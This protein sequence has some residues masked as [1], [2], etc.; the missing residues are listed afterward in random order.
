MAVI[1]FDFDGTISDENLHR[2][3]KKLNREGNQIWVVTMRKNTEFNRNFLQPVLS[4][5][6]LTQFNV[7][8]CN[9]KPKWELLKGINADI[10]IDNISDEFETLIN[11]TNVIPFLWV[12]T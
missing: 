9:D 11:H 7:I 4:K 1:A 6:G 2:I 5:I 3:V 12:V 10:Y 8:Y